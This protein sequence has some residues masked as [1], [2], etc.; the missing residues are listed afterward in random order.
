[1]DF[2]SRLT[3]SLQR[4]AA[5]PAANMAALATIVAVIVLAV[6]IVVLLILA[7]AVPGRRRRKKRN[8]SQSEARKAKPSIPAENPAP[9]SYANRATASASRSAR[10]PRTAGANTHSGTHPA[11]AAIALVLFVAGLLGALVLTYQL[12]ST[13]HYCANTCHAMDRAA[14]EWEHSA[15]SKVHCI[16]CHEG[17]KWQSIPNSVVLRLHDVSR[18]FGLQDERD[19]R[20]PATNCLA[21]HTRLMDAKLIGRNGEP[22][23][24]RQ[25]VTPRSRCGDCHGAQGHVP[26]RL[27]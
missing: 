16:D 1:M 4:L 26:G 11:A 5:D 22:F 6:L 15:H 24:H 2:F 9:A 14:N 20:V 8:K 18:Q 3:D 21:C 19:L 17:P 13:D 7:V 25:V 12:T 23:T 10:A 27:Q